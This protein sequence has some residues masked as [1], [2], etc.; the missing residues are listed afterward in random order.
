MVTLPIALK[1]HFASSKVTNYDVSFDQQI[2]WNNG[3]IVLVVLS[4]SSKLLFWYFVDTIIRKARDQQDRELIQEEGEFWRKSIGHD[5]VKEWEKKVRWIENI[6]D[7]RRGCG[8]DLIMPANL[9]KR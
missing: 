2:Q 5:T 7:G 6:S 4:I 9:R 3:L 8:W 1:T